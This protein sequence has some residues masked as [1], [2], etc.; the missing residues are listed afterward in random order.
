[1]GV[2]HWR[3]VDPMPREDGDVVL[4]VLGDLEDAGVL[5]QRLQPFNGLGQRIWSR[6]DLGSKSKPPSLSCS[7]P[8]GM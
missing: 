2:V 4:G 8:T 7:W 1:M 3:H 5:Q 6:A